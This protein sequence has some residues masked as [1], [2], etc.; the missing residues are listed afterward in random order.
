[1]DDPAVW[2]G[3][4]FVLGYLVRQIGLPPLVGFLAAGF[5]LRG[6]WDLE[7]TETLGH[8]ADLGVT[9]MLF[10]IGLKLKPKDLAQAPVW[11]GSTLHLVLSI[12][13]FL[14]L[15]LAGGAIG[16]PLLDTLD[17]ASGAV[18]AFALAFSEY[19]LRGGDVPK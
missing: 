2:I 11:L 5:L 6:V 12:G 10:T 19:R 9:L 4:A 1:M 16:I 15:L 8:V 14:P 18:V 13:F 17:L 7:Y 3:L